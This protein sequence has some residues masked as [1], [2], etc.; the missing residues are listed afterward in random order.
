M[1]PSPSSFPLYSRTH[2]PTDAHLTPQRAAGQRQARRDHPL[3]YRQHASRRQ[4]SAVGLIRFPRWPG[5]PGQHPH[6]RA[7]PPRHHRAATALTCNAATRTQ[8]G[9]ERTG[10]LSGDELFAVQCPKQWLCTAC[11]HSNAVG[12]RPSRDGIGPAQ[13]LLALASPGPG[14]PCHRARH[15]RRAQNPSPP[16][17]EARIELGNPYAGPMQSRCPRGP[18]VAWPQREPLGEEC[19]GNCGR[20]TGGGGLL[21]R[22]VRNRLRPETRNRGDALNKIMLMTLFE[23]GN[24]KYV[25][26]VSHDC[27]R[28]VMNLLCPTK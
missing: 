18:W 4:V 15:A 28:G 9:R 23:S 6:G 26:T 2:P 14:N 16:T 10:G 17:I 25:D 12:A 21:S 3:I 11:T 5:R 13:P 20:G 27:G 7:P 1:T 8:R 22:K 24:P 19:K